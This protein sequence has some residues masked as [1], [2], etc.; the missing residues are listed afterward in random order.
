MTV[1]ITAAIEIKLV[2]ADAIML[3][4]ATFGAAG[5]DLRACIPDA[6]PIPSRQRLVIPTG[7][8]IA[9]LPNYVGL[10]CPRS[11][12]A[13]KHGI[14]VLNAPGIVDSDYRGEVMVILYNTSTETYSIRPQ[15]RI[16]QLVVQ[17]VPVVAFVETICL[18]ETPRGAGGLGSTGEE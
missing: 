7:I 11:G 5:F 2:R 4:R 8:A 15:E 13:A 3:K 9:L 10:V 12:L 6:L 1:P 18:D 16:A 14:T 17:A